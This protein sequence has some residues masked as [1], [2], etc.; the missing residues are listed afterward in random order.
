MP[1]KAS[2][3]GR[4]GRRRSIPGEVSQSASTRP[5]RGF[6]DPGI[7]AIS[8][9]NPITPSPTSGHANQNPIT[10]PPISEYPKQ[11]PITPLPPSVYP[12]QNPI[13]P[14]PP[15]VYPNQ[16]STILPTASG[17]TNQKQNNIPNLPLGARQNTPNE[18]S[19]HRIL[20]PYNEGIDQTLAANYAPSQY[21][22]SQQ[23]D[24]EDE[25]NFFVPFAPDLPLQ[26][27]DHTPHLQPTPEHAPHLQQAPGHASH[28]QPT[29]G[30][31]PHLQQAPGHAPHIQPPGVVIRPQ[32]AQQLTSLKHI[33]NP[34][35]NATVRRYAQR[36]GFLTTFLA[37]IIIG[38][39]ILGILLFGPKPTAHAATPT[40]QLLGFASP[41]GTLILHGEGFTPGDK[42]GVT[43]D[44]QLRA[45]GSDEPNSMDINGAFFHHTNTTPAV[46]TITRAVQDDGTLNIPIPVDSQWAVGSTHTVY[47]YY[48]NSSKVMRL[49]FT[50]S[51][52]EAQ[53][54]LIGCP[55]EAIAINL[56]SM[57]EGSNTHISKL[58]TLC[59]TGAGQV[60][61][62]A[63]GMPKWLQLTSK[64]QITAPNTGQVALNASANGLRPGSYSATITFSSTQSNARVTSNVILVVLKKGT[65]SG[66]PPQGTPPA[67][68]PAT[69][70]ISS[71]L[72]TL[73]FNAVAHQSSNLLQTVTISNCGDP[74]A[75]SGS[76]SMNNGNQWLALGS[77]GGTLNTGNLQDINILA[78]SANLNAGK[79]TGQITF[80]MGSSSTVVIVIFIVSSPQTAPPCISSYQKTLTFTGFAGQDDPPE[81]QIKLV[82]CGA[83]GHWSAV[84]NTDDETDW[85]DNIT[86]RS[87]RSGETQIIKIGV[88]G[89][90]L[91]GGTYRGK[92]TIIMG[93]CIVRIYI[94]FKVQTSCIHVVT[95]QLSFQGTEEDEDT[96]QNHAVI[97]NCGAEGRWYASTVTDDGRDWLSVSPSSHHIDS[98]AYQSITVNA[99]DAHLKHGI[100]TGIVYFAIGSSIDSLVVTF[101]ITNGTGTPG[102]GDCLNVSH[103]HL[104]F[105]VEQ[106]Q[107]D[108][109]PQTVY[110]ENC[111]RDGSWNVAKSDSWLHVNP[112][113]GSIHYGEIQPVQISP[114]SAHFSRGDHQGQIIFTSGKASQT[115]TITLTIQQSARAC[116][117]ASPISL[118]FTGYSANVEK[119]N[120]GSQTIHISNCGDD[121]HLSASDHAARDDGSPWLSLS[122]GNRELG[123]GQGADFSVSVNSASLSVGTYTATL[124][125]TIVTRTGA[126]DRET[127]N[128]TL[129]VLAPTQTEPTGT[130]TKCHISPSSLTF[131]STQNQGTPQE[132]TVTISNCSPGASWT[133]TDDSG[134]VLQ[135]ND[136]GTLDSNGNQTISLGPDVHPTPVGK[137]SYHVNFAISTGETL[138][139]GVNWKSQAPS[140]PTCIQAS[141]SS[142]SFKLEEGQKTDMGVDFTNCGGENGTITVDGSGSGWLTIR[143]ASGGAIDGSSSY[144]PGTGTSIDANI[145]SSNMPVNTYQESITG[146][147]NTSAGSKAVTVNVEMLVQTPQQPPVDPTPIPSVEPSVTPSVTVS[148]SPTDTSTAIPSVTP[149]PTDT[150]TATPSV[151]PSP[152]DTPTAAPSV[153]PSPTNTSTAAPGVTPS[154]TDTSTAAPSVTPSPTDTSTAAPSVTPTDTPTA[155]PTNTPTATDTPTP[156]P[157]TPTPIP[158]TPVPPTPTLVPPAPTPIPPTPTPVPTD[159]PTPLPAP[160]DTS[161]GGG[162][163]SGQ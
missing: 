64:G 14:L 80:H 123:A 124:P 111:G 48:N 113:S 47:L 26:A 163:P 46:Q 87:I 49:A 82:G 127:V 91:S 118:I 56:G 88:S 116:I 70:C 28:L 27:P 43:V 92:I 85:I 101:N 95:Q 76:T 125:F 69:A 106:G 51:L 143:S 141:V 104:D 23:E 79:Y 75:W 59:T 161:G 72:P 53:P 55:N 66:T 140:N 160:T 4:C 67:A 81:Q 126:T 138:G 152:T 134:G 54:E 10:L 40:A 148:P 129:N 34:L 136:A 50:V 139:V 7:L 39:S 11:N 119:Q 1:E 83:S 155:V 153:T 146:T 17:Y 41:G 44:I 13:T 24:E 121:G 6:S 156:V 128:V 73:S 112:D 60:S 68:N 137:F 154:P 99:S 144:S 132:Q 22:Y 150:S 42:V 25:E 151:T 15:S 33:Q 98:D 86:G 102:I 115:V 90:Q 65:K 84:L 16:D 122:G 61:W 109:D 8:K 5:G 135:L 89:A 93:S 31:A 158:P 19:D 20:H 114:S 149:S 71:T 145:D 29:A 37:V 105:T 142:K 52:H 133:E 45:Q 107:G 117:D 110:L 130:K 96:E 120:P 63:A 18:D 30:H 162:T 97:H 159:T 36:P 3:C 74:G 21:N 157:P 12:N 62:S 57:V 100:H 78:S 9:Q 108:P 77:A 147:I 35:R 103:N 58:L 38:A 94:I 2:F 131:N 32:Q